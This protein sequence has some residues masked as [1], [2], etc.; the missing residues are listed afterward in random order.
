MAV[1]S[2]TSRAMK[3]GKEMRLSM[4]GGKKPLN[5]QHKALLIPA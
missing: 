4:G 1:G 5:P 3:K 2:Q